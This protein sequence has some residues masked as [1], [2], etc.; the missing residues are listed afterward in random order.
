[1]ITQWEDAFLLILWLV[2]RT[3]LLLN[4]Q[5]LGGGVGITRCGCTERKDWTQVGRKVIKEQIEVVDLPIVVQSK[6][7]RNN[8]CSQEICKTYSKRNFIIATLELT[9][10]D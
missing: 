3:H 5:L 2:V 10:M 9:C 8:Y 6:I 7:N 1:M 4:Y